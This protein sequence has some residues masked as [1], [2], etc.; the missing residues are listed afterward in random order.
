MPAESLRGRLTPVIAAA[1]RFDVDCQST[2]AAVEAQEHGVDRVLEEVAAWLQERA[3][4]Y[5]AFAHDTYPP[6]PDHNIVLG[7]ARIVEALANSFT[8][9]SE[10]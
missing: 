1:V 9:G 6:G 5:R 7:Q 2:E 4:R 10:Q 8:R 3:D